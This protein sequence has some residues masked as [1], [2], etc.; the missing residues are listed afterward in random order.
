[1]TIFD[2]VDLTTLPSEGSTEGVYRP[3]NKTH[4]LGGVLSERCFVEPEG[5]LYHRPKV[6][7]R[8]VLY[9]YFIYDGQ[10]ILIPDFLP[11]YSEVVYGNQFVNLSGLG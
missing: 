5:E 11:C 6:L 4:N 3:F 2:P 8:R 7:I 9:N 10:R 1:M